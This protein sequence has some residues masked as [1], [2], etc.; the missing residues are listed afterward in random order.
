MTRD[1]ETVVVYTIKRG[2]YFGEDLLVDVNFKLKLN[3]IRRQ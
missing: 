3:T 1:T 2:R